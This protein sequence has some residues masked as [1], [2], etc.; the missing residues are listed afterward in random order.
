M[1]WWAHPTR[2][3]LTLG[4]AQRVQHPFH[5]QQGAGRQRSLRNTPPVHPPRSRAHNAGGPLPQQLSAARQVQRAEQQRCQCWPHVSGGRELYIQQWGRPQQVPLPT[6]VA[7][8]SQPGC[9]RF[10]VFQAAWVGSHRQLPIST[11]RLRLTVCH[12]GWLQL[13]PLLAQQRAHLAAPPR[14]TQA[15]PLLHGG[16]RPQHEVPAQ[17]PLPAAVCPGQLQLALRQQACC[18]SLLSLCAA[19]AAAE[20]AVKRLKA[21]PSVSQLRAPPKQ[22][23][24]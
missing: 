8:G 11:A 22:Q 13:L 3:A 7:Q 16:S 15:G 14:L 23:H 9:Q 21:G 6:D 19:A 12:Q 24:A 20:L 5:A 18:R 10:P 2:R 4:A 17:R 1:R